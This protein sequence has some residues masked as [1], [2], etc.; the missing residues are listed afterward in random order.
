MQAWPLMP[1]DCLLGLKRPQL[2]DRGMSQAPEVQGASPQVH[3][4]RDFPFRARLVRRRKPHS[5][6]PTQRVPQ[7]WKRPSRPTDDAAASCSMLCV[8]S[9]VGSCFP[10]VSFVDFLHDTSITPQAAAQRC[11]SA[12]LSFPDS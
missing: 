11:A 2:L 3:R 1:R 5:V 6:R 9:C 10:S 12:V 7:Q 8:S 4:N